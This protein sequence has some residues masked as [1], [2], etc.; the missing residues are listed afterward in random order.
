VL[1]RVPTSRGGTYALAYTNTGTTLSWGGGSAINV[2]A[3]G[4]FTLTAADGSQI[5]ATV[6]AGSLPGTDQS[7][8]INLRHVKCGRIAE[9]A[10]ATS[11]YVDILTAARA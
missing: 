2:S 9:V 8:N 11:V 7:D 6:T 10:S 1:T 3:G 4:D 5:L